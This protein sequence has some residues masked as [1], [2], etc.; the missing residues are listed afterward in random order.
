MPERRRLPRMAERG[1]HYDATPTTRE[2]WQRQVTADPDIPR[3]VD[4]LHRHIEMLHGDGAPRGHCAYSIA[5]RFTAGLRNPDLTDH[6]IDDVDAHFHEALADLP[7]SVESTYFHVSYTTTGG[8]AVTKAVAQSTAADL[9]SHYLLYKG[10]FGKAPYQT[11]TTHGKQNVEIHDINGDGYVT[12]SGPINLDNASMNNSHNRPWTTA[13]ELFHC[14]EFAFGL[15]TAGHD[16]ADWFVEAAANWAATFALN[17]V[18]DGFWGDFTSYQTTSIFAESYEAFPLWVYLNG[19]LSQSVTHQSNIWDVKTFLE[20]YESGGDSMAALQTILNIAATDISMVTTIPAL[21]ARY[22]AAK[23]TTEW[24]ENGSGYTRDTI[25]PYMV[26][27]TNYNSG[28]A[29]PP[30]AIPY[31][32]TGSLTAVDTP[33]AFDNKTLA[34]GAANL[35]HL[36]FNPGQ[37]EGKWV[38]VTVSKASGQPAITASA[39]SASGTSGDS[40]SPVLDLDSSQTNA[41]VTFQMTDSDTDTL[42]VAV[43]DGRLGGTTSGNITYSLSIEVQDS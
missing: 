40:V 17:G 27:M 37:F 11:S 13:H 2:D 5:K 1:H 10:L 24:R 35:F 31:T 19:F 34:A 26:D 9:D 7:D 3:D 30:P 23:A 4:G 16:G 14:V 43:V 21:V 12:R 38:H 20:T 15:D 32:G 39:L 18:V 25:M 41:N 36:T 33:V 28:N 42:Y 22:T 29:N 8:S 6:H